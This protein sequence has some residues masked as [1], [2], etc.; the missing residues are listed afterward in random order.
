MQKL[1]LLLF[2]LAISIPVFSQVNCPSSVTDIDGNTYSVIQAGNYCWMGENLRVT[3]FADGTS[4]PVY[5]DSASWVQNNSSIGMVYQGFDSTG[6]YE[7]GALYNWL[8]II[9]D[10]NGQNKPQGICPDG[11]YVPS[12]DNWKELEM[13]LGMSQQSADSTGWRGS[14]EGGDLKTTGTSYWNNPNVGATNLSGMSI[15]GSAAVWYNGTYQN[16]NENAYFWTSTE[17]GLNATMRNLSYDD[18]RVR[19]LNFLKRDAMACRCISDGMSVGI[20]ETN[21]TRNSQTI[22]RIIDSM[23]RKVT[24]VKPYQVYIYIYSD[25][26]YEKKVIIE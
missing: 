5:L 10:D 20:N 15:K 8:A 22:I 21:S 2:A 9:Y 13:S 4:I 12:D 18:A 16:Y 3:T 7:Y 25:G 14:D 1:S 24:E 23:G 17:S 6:S 26:S 19:R 11:W